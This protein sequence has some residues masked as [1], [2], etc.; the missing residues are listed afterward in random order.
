MN[1]VWSPLL[2]SEAIKPHWLRWYFYYTMMTAILL[3][4]TPYMQKFIY[5]QFYE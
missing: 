3:L 5:F 4:S 1:K 2:P